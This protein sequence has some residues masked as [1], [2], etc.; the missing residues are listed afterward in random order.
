MKHIATC[1]LC[2]EKKKISSIYYWAESGGKQAQYC[3]FCC[4]N[5]KYEV[6]EID[7]EISEEKLIIFYNIKYARS[8]YTIEDINKHA[9]ALGE[10]ICHFKKWGNITPPID[11]CSFNDAIVNWQE[12]AKEHLPN[13]KS[14]QVFI[15]DYVYGRL[16]MFKLASCTLQKEPN[17]KK[18]EE[19]CNQDV[20]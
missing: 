12:Y 20:C 19:L 4:Q 3:K 18:P 8:I 9:K 17:G 2:N 15:Q 16:N 14:A 11:S 13:F 5:V 6:V 1:D 10:A 7:D